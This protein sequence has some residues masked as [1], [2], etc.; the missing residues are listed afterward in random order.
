MSLYSY[1]GAEP[2]K[3]PRSIYVGDNLLLTD[4]STL[5]QNE[6]EKLGFT[7]PYTVPGI[8]DLQYAAWDS[9]TLSYIIFD[10]PPDYAPYKEKV[11]YFPETKTISIVSLS[12]AEINANYETKFAE[13]RAK[14]Y[15]LF[16]K[17]DFAVSL[18]AEF[19]CDI[20]EPEVIQYQELIEYKVKLRDLLDG[21][22]NPFL[23]V[24]PT[25]PSK[26]DRVLQGQYGPVYESQA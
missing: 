22:T 1:K 23:V 9:D 18:T 11:V 2:T 24:F 26:L 20:C 7:G 19:M 14:R 5:D 10:L 4:L 17:A 3:L 8:T 6:L 25:P 21:V 16:T 13:I 15:E 12:E